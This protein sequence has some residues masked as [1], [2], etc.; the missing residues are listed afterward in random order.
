MGVVG[1]EGRVRTRLEVG[2]PRRRA[3]GCSDQWYADLDPQYFRQPPTAAPPEQPGRVSSGHPSRALTAHKSH[4]H[5]PAAV[6]EPRLD[7]PSALGPARS[8]PQRHGGM[9]DD[10]AMTTSNGRWPRRTLRLDCFPI[11]PQIAHSLKIEG[12]GLPRAGTVLGVVLGVVRPA[13]RE[14]GVATLP[15]RR[16]HSEGKF[17]F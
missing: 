4:S 7:M 1:E 11:F 14:E 2:T 10:T 9:A 3:V 17:C 13:S 5:I 16:L 15:G 8:P 6:L 12:F